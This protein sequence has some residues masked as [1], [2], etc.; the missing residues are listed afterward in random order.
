MS[1]RV[2][3][4]TFFLGLLMVYKF[5]MNWISD[6]TTKGSKQKWLG[7][8]HHRPPSCGSGYLLRTFDAKEITQKYIPNN[9][10]FKQIFLLDPPFFG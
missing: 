9:E 5:G 1:V 7:Q 8:D 6:G 10:V 2:K 4:L 3:N